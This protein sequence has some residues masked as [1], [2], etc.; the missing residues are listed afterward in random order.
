MALDRRTIAIAAG[1]AAVLAGWLIWRRESGARCARHGRLVSRW[2]SVRGIR[3]HARVSIDAV[4][5]GRPPVVLVHG[6]GMSSR[7]MVPLAKCLAADFRVHA[8]DLPG[9]G[10]SD[11]PCGAFS[12]GELADVLAAWMDEAR[13]PRAAFVGN[14]LGCE[15]LVDFALRYP[16]RVL[17]LVLQGPTPDPAFLS[18]VRQIAHFFVT[19]LFERPSLGWVAPSDYLRC[20]VRRYVST[21]RDMIANRI[22]GKLPRIAAPTLVVWGTRDYLVPRRSAERVARLLP[23][24]SLAVIPGAAHG[25]NYSQPGPLKDC[26]LDFVL[27]RGIE[28]GSPARRRGRRGRQEPSW[29]SLSRTPDPETRPR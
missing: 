7:Y 26:V 28:P 18:P 16:G 24:G 2:S 17:S 21:F 11:K 29:R 15:I 6:L 1:A 22:E 19:G 13:I 4:P 14:S 10:L 5:I 23:Q 27:G 20:G 9:F 12:V 8:P 3:M 25:I